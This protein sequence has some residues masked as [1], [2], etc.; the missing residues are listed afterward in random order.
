MGRFQRGFVQVGRVAGVPVRLHWTAPLGALVLSGFHWA[1]VRWLVVLGLIVVHEL[2]HAAVVKAVRAR[3]TAIEVTGFG[4]LC[5]WE[6]EVTPIGRAAIAWGGVAAQLLLLW[7]ALAVEALGWKPAS[8]AAWQVWSTLTFSNAWLIAI[9]LLPFSPLDGGEAWSL[10]VL[11][12]ASLRQRVVRKAAPVGP[13]PLPVEV[14]D[15]AFEAGDRR[16]EVSALVKSM[17]DGARR[18]EEDEP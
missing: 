9:N 4:G 18:D 8:E 16:E 10:P 12:G 3:A 11:L 15:E 2:G 5:W 13:A 14:R 1:P 7:A 17:L 6:G